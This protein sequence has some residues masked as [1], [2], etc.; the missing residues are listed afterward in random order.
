M[1]SQN[2]GINRDENASAMS[3]TIRNGKKERM[4]HNPAMTPG[5]ALSLTIL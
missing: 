4:A 2:E 1:A 5:H 3:K